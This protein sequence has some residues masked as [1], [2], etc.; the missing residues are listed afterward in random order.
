VSIRAASRPGGSGG[1]AGEGHDRGDPG[2]DGE[3]QGQDGDLGQVGRG[4]PPGH[5]VRAGPPGLGPG[6][7]AARG[8]LRR[9][10]PGRVAGAPAGKKIDSPYDPEAT[11]GNELSTT[12]TGYEVHLTETC[13]DDRVHPI[14]DVETTPAVAADADQTA[15]IQRL[16]RPGGCC[17]AITCRM[18]ATWT[19]SCW[20]AARPSTTCGRSVRYAPT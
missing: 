16:W 2:R 5:R 20:W 3:H 10:R 7:P 15:S 18:P 17:R 6:L 19:A 11:Y 12:W 13:E 1:T 4:L 14:T 9:R 8:R